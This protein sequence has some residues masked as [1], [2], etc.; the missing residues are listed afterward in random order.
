MEKKK[1]K[2]RMIIVLLFIAIFALG[3]FISLR[4]T[5]LQYKEFGDNFVQ[6]F[7]TNLKY[8]YIIFGV[9]F[10]ILYFL[11]YFVN[12]GI[13]KGLSVF[14]EKENR[15]KPKLLNKSIA[16]VISVIV[17]AVMSNILMEKIL[18]C[19]SEATFGIT[20]PIFNLDISF[21]MFQ[22]PLIEMLLWYFIG[23]VIG[24]TGYMVIY[25]IIVFNKYF[26]GV[27]GKMIRESLLVKKAI[28]NVVLVIIGVALFTVLNIT[29]ISFNKMLTI[30]NEADTTQN[31]EIIGAGYTDVMIQRWGYLIFAFII[32]F[33]TLKAVKAFKD[34]NTAKVLKNLIMIPGYLVVMFLVIIVF[35]IVF[36]NSNTLDKEKQYLED[37]IKYTKNAYNIDIEEENLES[38]GTIT[39]QEVIENDS[40]INN[41]KVVNSDVVLKTLDDSQT[42]TGYYSYRSANIAKYKISGEDKLVYVSPREIANSGR[43]YNNKTYEYTHGTGQIVTS[44]TSVTET[45]TLE[46]IQK[47]VSGNDDKIGTTQ[48][49]IYFGLE[50][51]DT[52]ATNTKNKQEYD[53]TDENGK[54]HVSTYNGKAGLQLDFIDRLIL[55]TRTGELKLALSTEVTKDSKILI[56]RIII[57]RAKKAMPYLIYDENPYTVVTDEGRIVWVLD[58]YT[59][60]NKYPYSQYTSIEHDGIKEKINYIRNS[61]KVIIDS[62]D[63][64]MQFYITD[65]TDPIAMAYRNVYPTLFEDLNSEISQDISEHFIYPEYLYN[66]QAELLKIYH[67][68]KPDVLYRTDDLWDFAK[69][70]STI[71]SK[72]SGTELKPYYTMVR[73]DGQNDIGLI[74]I[75]TQDSKQNLISYLVGTTDGSANKLKMYKFSPDSNIFGPMQLDNQIEQDELISSEIQNLNTTGAK[76]TKDMVIVPVNN[77]LLYVESIYQT[78]LNEES[79]IPMLKKVVVASGNKVAIGDNLK[80]AL[81]NLLSKDASNIEVE[82]TEDIDGLIDA[83][84]KA[85]KNLSESTG[86]NDWELMGSDIKKLQSLIDSLEELKNEEDKK[87]QEQ[88]KENNTVSNSLNEEISNEIIE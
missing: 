8:K 45:G 24:L 2:S 32:V 34:N 79:K 12:K 29:D 7:F 86:N 49:G 84:I 43:T 70:N 75:Y 63:G 76:V 9:N 4:G 59:V 64:T 11:I 65:K 21:Y 36:V 52:I 19:S 44:A 67:N 14:F 83:I 10:T 15:K 88:E 40:I 68:V 50:T 77:T 55:G 41:I 31:I 71:I 39:Q 20:D 18:V 35:N 27:D 51:N 60:S 47:D 42:G 6:V 23:I 3:S 73:N 85:N 30:K 82:N 38:T 61:V 74:Q 48:Q 58:A 37:N 54:E 26:D 62:Y 87:K 56:N 25:Y 53:Y 46:Y 5:Y 28:R 1:S 81:N 80:Q 69:Y 17:S 72:S 78:M 66:V 13:K 57:E 22:K 33:A 16:F